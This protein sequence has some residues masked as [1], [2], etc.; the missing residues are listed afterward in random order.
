[1]TD[2]RRNQANRSG[3]SAAVFDLDGTILDTIEDLAC[4]VNHA[5]R[6][7]GLPE[8]P[9]AHTRASV[10]NGIRLLIEKSVPAGTPADLADAVFDDFRSYYA[11]HSRERTRP[12]PGVAEAVAE[13]T[14][15][16]VAC[17]VVSNKVDDVVRDLAAAYYPGAFRAVVGERPGIPRKPAPD[18][19][20]AVLEELGVPAA[21]N[22]A[23]TPHAVYIGDSEVDIATAAAAGLPCISVTWGFRG[24][25]A[26]LAAGA[27]T[28]VDSPD[29]L[30]ACVLSI[31]RRPPN[32]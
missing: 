24:R 23:G 4:A 19:T 25:D 16:G 14:A 8:Q 29:E 2:R 31:L 32:A 7:H 5:L 3:A 6:E 10:G 18:S 28:L 1:M 30:A 13:L 21:S 22:T 26:L 12:Y 11:A 15:A 27:T 9:L 17:G 20:F